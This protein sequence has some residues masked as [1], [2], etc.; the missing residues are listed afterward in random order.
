MVNVKR[1]LVSFKDSLIANIRR[2][3]K[4]L[5][6][7]SLAFFFFLT[8]IPLVALIGNFISLFDLPYSSIGNVVESYFPKGTTTLLEV[9]TVKFDFS[10]NFIVFLVS[11]IML[12]S[13]ATHS[14]IL[15]SNQIY[16]IKNRR[17]IYRR[18]KALIMMLI[19]ILLLIFILF[20]PVFG[21][22]IFKV[23]AK[24]NN[25]YGIRNTIV[26]LYAILK[27]PL[28]LAF[29]YFSIRLLYIMAPDKKI[30]RNNVFY[31]S[32]FTTVCWILVTRIYSV[33]VEKFTNYTTFYGGLASI[34]ILMLWLYLLSYIFVLGMALN[35]SK[36]EIE[37]QTKK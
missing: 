10:I 36:Y 27:Y 2:P 14:M 5:L 32:V 31:G 6:P 26:R 35:A 4:K 33:Y 30:K 28:S 24:L 23:I 17:Y 9:I 3:E 20:V 1:E 18:G 13:N 37:E 12:A 16:K 7:G 19:V 25:Y 29:I 21:N 34:L 8:M 11:A 22:T 15:V